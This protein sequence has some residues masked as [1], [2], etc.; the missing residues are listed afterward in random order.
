MLPNHPHS[1]A[2]RVSQITINLSLSPDERHALR[3]GQY[4]AERTLVWRINTS[5]GNT[6]DLSYDADSLNESETTE[7]IEDTLRKLQVI[8][9][10]RAASVVDPSA[11]HSQFTYRTLQTTM[12][13]LSASTNQSV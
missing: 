11:E 9:D 2:D 4:Q 1:L 10:N 3:N 7:L 6:V 5:D 8:L 12:N 13:I